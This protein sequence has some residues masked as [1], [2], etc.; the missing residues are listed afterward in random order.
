MCDFAVEGAGGAVEGGSALEGNCRSGVAA[1]T[2]QTRQ[3]HLQAG[4][5]TKKKGWTRR[6]S[7]AHSHTARTHKKRRA[8]KSGRLCSAD[9]TSA[10]HGKL[11]KAGEVSDARTNQLAPLDAVAQIRRPRLRV[12]PSPDCVCPTNQMKNPGETVTGEPTIQTVPIASASRLSSFTLSLSSR[13]SRQGLEQRFCV[14]FP[15]TRLVEF[16]LDASSP[17]AVDHQSHLSTR[18]AF[19]MPSYRAPRLFSCHC[20][21]PL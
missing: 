16:V 6:R 21:A 3:A 10:A 18:L 1:G 14:E 9:L 8:R 7:M 15:Q 17:A 20:G 2:T 13:A 4:S 5:K 12:A 19:G 11:G